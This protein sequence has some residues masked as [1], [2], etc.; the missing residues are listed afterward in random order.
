M[1]VEY[2]DYYKLLG[3][4]KSATKEEIS[5]AFKKLARKYHPDLNPD[6][7]EAE[8]KFKSI[9]EAYEVLKDPEKRRMYDQLG[10]NWKD[11]Q[12]FRSGGFE[13]MNF[14]G[15][16]GSGFSDFFETLFGGGGMGG[17]G[18]FSQGGYNAYGG[19]PRPRK[20]RDVEAQISVSLEEANAGC[21]KSITLQNHDGSPK[22]LQVNI[23][24]GMKDGGRMRLSGQGDAGMAGGPAGDLYLRIQYAPH[25]YY[26]VDGSNLLY[27]L[28]L[29]PWEA[30]LGTK[31][32][33][34]TLGG[35]VMLN[36]APLS[37]SGKKLRLRGKGMGGKETGD[38]IV[39]VQIRMPEAL[40]DKEKTLW[41][42][43]ADLSKP[44]GNAEDGAEQSA[45]SGTQK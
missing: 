35:A 36:I 42:E 30:A 18:G 19:S 24:A 29:A 23:P 17:M 31:A 27:D 25:A 14:G 4:E 34:P 11:G 16:G 2:K 13:N 39:T 33:V 1:A 26:K 37:S 3:V 38:L 22:T 45:E 10:P 7:A 20:G 43:L 21:K 28:A 9:N 5:K 8:E 40:S 12:Q 6:N 32:E 41:Q 15:M 44:A